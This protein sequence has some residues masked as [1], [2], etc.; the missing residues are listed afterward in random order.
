[1]VL[2]AG[3]LYK[4]QLEG[5]K[6]ENKKYTVLVEFTEKVNSNVSGNHNEQQQ[7]QH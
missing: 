1:V 6:K 7:K 4:D 2:N 3:V 5:K